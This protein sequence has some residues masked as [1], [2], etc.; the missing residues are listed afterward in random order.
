MKQILLSALVSLFIFPACRKTS[1]G[2]PVAGDSWKLIEVYDKNTATT[3]L[4]PAGRNREVVITFLSGNK[5]SGQ[6]LNNIITDGTYTQNGNDITFHAYSMTKV[7]EDQW[8]GSFHTVLHACYLQSV[9][10]CVPSKITV[11]GNIMK[12]ASPMRYNITLEKL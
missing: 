10:P 11:Q 1:S 6:T 9:M 5:F 8:G 2:D 4:P 7:A 3:I 12:I